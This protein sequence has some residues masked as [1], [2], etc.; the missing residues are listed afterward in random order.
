MNLWSPKIWSNYFFHVCYHAGGSTEGFRLRGPKVKRRDEESSPSNL[1]LEKR[2]TRSACKTR[3]YLL[4]CPLTPT[5]RAHFLPYAFVKKN[6]WIQQNGMNRCDTYYSL[7]LIL[8]LLCDVF[9]FLVKQGVPS[10]EDLEWLSQKLKK[11]KTVGR[12]LQIDDGRL[13]AFDNEDRR[14]S[15]KIYKMLLHWKERDWLN[16]NI[17]DP[18]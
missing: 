13:A 6:A 11:W 17:H 8:M 2:K 18:T 5:P 1:T 12:R 7:S 3:T 10:D 14:R 15:E 9:M 4:V 16:C